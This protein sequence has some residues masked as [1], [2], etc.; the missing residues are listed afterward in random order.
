MSSSRMLESTR[1]ANTFPEETTTKDS[2]VTTSAREAKEKRVL[3]PKE[4]VE[5][6]TVEEEAT[7]EVTSEENTEEAEVVTITRETRMLTKMALRLFKKRPISLREAEEV[8]VAEVASEAASA[9][10]RE[11]PE[12]ASEVTEE[13]T[14]T[15]RDPDAAEV[16][17]ALTKILQSSQP[18]LR[19]ESL[20]GQHNLSSA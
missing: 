18:P 9:E 4:E 6:A 2:T 19:N 15:S 5:E 12:A 7:E 14:T 17:S 8:A 10:A 3:T 20:E 11:V 16:R 1:K 13:A